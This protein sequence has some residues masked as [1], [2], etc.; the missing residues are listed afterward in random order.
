MLPAQIRSV[1]ELH[2]MELVNIDGHRADVF[3]KWPDGRIIRPMMIAIQDVYSRKFLA[4]RIAENEDMVTARLVFADL[5]QTWGIPKR[6]LADNGRAFV[7]QWLSGGAKTRLR[8][9]VRDVH[10]AGLLVPMGF[11]RPR[12]T[13]Y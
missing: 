5:F 6:L 12:A 13:H 1:A 7:S 9:T 8:F 2:A 11:S 3:V 10:P 4:W